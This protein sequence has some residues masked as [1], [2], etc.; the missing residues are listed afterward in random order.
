MGLSEMKRATMLGKFRDLSEIIRF[1]SAYLYHL[2]DKLPYSAYK[3]GCY[4]KCKMWFYEKFDSSCRNYMWLQLHYSIKD[5][6]L[7]PRILSKIKHL[8]KIDEKIN[9]KKKCGLQVC[10]Q[11]NK[12]MIRAK[13]FLCLCSAVVCDGFLLLLVCVVVIWER[14]SIL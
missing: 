11:R 6:F 14:N 8:G 4:S 7:T 10:Y 13:F 12:S 1:M 2:L 5:I 9:G 3:I